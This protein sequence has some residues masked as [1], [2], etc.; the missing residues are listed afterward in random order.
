MKNN[1]HGVLPDFSK[2]FPSGMHD[3]KMIVFWLAVAVVVYLVIAKR[4]SFW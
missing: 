4:G 2:L 1:L 3:Y